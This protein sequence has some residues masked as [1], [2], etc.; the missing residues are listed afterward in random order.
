MYFRLRHWHPITTVP[1][2][3]D[4]E[5]RVADG[6]KSSTLEFPCQQTN[7]GDWINGDLRTSID[8]QPLEWRVWRHT[9][10]PRPHH[11]AVKS[12]GW[13]VGPRR[14]HRSAK[15]ARPEQMKRLEQSVR[16]QKNLAGMA[17][18][19]VGMVVTAAGVG[20]LA[21]ISA[22][23]LPIGLSGPTPSSALHVAPAS[24]PHAEDSCKNFAYAFLHP[25]CLTFQKKH[26]FRGTHRFATLLIGRSSPHP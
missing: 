9:Q 7:A 15:R 13:S 23:A 14:T 21:Q 17:C 26:A 24:T 12:K 5:L 25:A 19:V 8:I 4:V 3:R 6:T 2:N 11:A 20:S 1:C 18:V 16:P 10:S 22:W